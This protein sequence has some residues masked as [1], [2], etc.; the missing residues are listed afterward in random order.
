MDAQVLGDR[1][2]LIWTPPPPDGCGPLTFVVVRKRSGAL[3]HPGDGT[4]IAE[5]SA[6]E[7]DDRH[8]TPGETVGYA[9]LSK[10]GAVESIAAISLG[11]FIFLADVKDVQVAAGA[12][13]VA[14]TWQP[15]PGVAEVR[16][17]RKRGAAPTGPRDGERLAAAFDHLLDRG[18]DADQVYYYGIY[19]IYKMPDG[20]LYPSPGV[21]VSARPGAP[22]TIATR[23]D[24]PIAEPE[25]PALPA[26]P[27][28]LRATRAG[29]GRGSGLRRVT[30][31]WQWASGTASALIAARQG[32][33]SQGPDD[34]LATT[35]V[36]PRA[37]Y[38]R[39]QCWTF[40]LPSTPH[41]S[42]AGPAAVPGHSAN[43]TATTAEPASPDGGAW[44]IR[45]Y[46]LAESDGARISSPGEE[47]SAATILPGPRPEV[48]VSYTLKR[49]WLP[50]APWSL[51]FRTE[52]ADATTPPLVVVAHPR[53][54]PLS[55]DDGQI[56]A[57][58]P[59]AGDG[60]RVSIPGRFRLNG[61]G[62]RVF[63]DP[64]VPP[65]SLRPIRFRHPETGPT[66]V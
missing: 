6:A 42:L 55:V 22:I 48:T 54:V 1:I 19:V 58:L 34:P 62:V 5:I 50:G 20:R 49:P 63:P 53:T 65:D 59:A 41:R 61:H 30:L 57:R 23:P 37:D 26:D 44:H 60:T 28:D 29:G 4:R 32:V 11:P 45:V 15:P 8:L 47:P 31:R 35:F 33:P 51:T 24:L 16:A 27:T 13:E 3:G 36:V 14:L 25:R 39:Q 2:R 38:E 46:S 10:R 43:G 56:I 17:I 64:N 12:D 9:V 7:F 52:P 21:V 18:V 66:R 40:T